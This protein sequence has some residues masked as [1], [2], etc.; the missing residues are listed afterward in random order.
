MERFVDVAIQARKERA[1]REEEEYSSGQKSGYSAPTREVR[2]CH[3]SRGNAYQRVDNT[4]F[5]STHPY[6]LACPTR[7][8]THGIMA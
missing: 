6:R 5:Q 4:R 1:L 8:Q 3:F 2:K 7:F